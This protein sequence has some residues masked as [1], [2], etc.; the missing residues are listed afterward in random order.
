MEAI[1]RIEHVEG[2]TLVL[3]LPASFRGKRVEV[4]VL[5][6]AGDEQAAPPPTPRR[7]PPAALAGKMILRDDLVSPAVP[8]TDWDAH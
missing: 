2:H 1:R 3:E 5:E 8:E 4:I 7:H 6:I